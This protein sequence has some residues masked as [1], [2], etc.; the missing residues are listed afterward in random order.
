M[1][2]PVGVENTFQGAPISLGV[3][4]GFELKN[5]LYKTEH[6]HNALCYYR[7]NYLKEKIGSFVVIYKAGV[8]SAKW[9]HKIA[10]IV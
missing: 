2:P 9:T 1:Y 10:F 4:I 8:Q 7:F 5:F 3:W 6:L